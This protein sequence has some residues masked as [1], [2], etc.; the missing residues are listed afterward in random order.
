M[1]SGS[2]IPGRHAT[3]SGGLWVL[4]V[5]TVTGMLVP[6]VMMPVEPGAEL[7]WHKPAVIAGFV[8]GLLGVLG[9][10]VVLMSRGERALLPPPRTWQRPRWVVDAVHRVRARLART[11][12]TGTDADG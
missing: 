12:R 2:C 4:I 6:F 11:A 7:W 9:Y 5:F 8:V 1:R 10:I 3:L